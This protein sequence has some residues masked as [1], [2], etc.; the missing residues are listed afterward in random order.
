M[1]TIDSLHFYDPEHK[2]RV[3]KFKNYDPNSKDEDSCYQLLGFYFACMYNNG[4]TTE[5]YKII[6][7]ILENNPVTRNIFWMMYISYV[8]LYQNN[9]DVA[10]ATQQL[11]LDVLNGLPKSQVEDLIDGEHHYTQ[12]K[13][14]YKDFCNDIFKREF[15]AANKDVSYYS[16]LE[17]RYPFERPVYKCSI[18]SDDED[19]EMWESA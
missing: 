10:K 6:K 3:L 15:Q 1:T 5:E 7:Y 9:H 17:N 19:E 14:S 12:V 11:I 8:Q 16:E 4:D 13:Q 18:D 2:E